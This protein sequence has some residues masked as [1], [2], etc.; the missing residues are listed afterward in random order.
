MFGLNMAI[1]ST[2]LA[3]KRALGVNHTIPPAVMALGKIDFF[4][5]RPRDR[6]SGEHDG[7]AGAKFR[8]QGTVRISIQKE[9][10]AQ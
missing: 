3:S 9:M 1:R 4:P 7:S 8:D 10:L 5:S 2:E 6:P